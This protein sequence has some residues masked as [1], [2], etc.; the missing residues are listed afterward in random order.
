[1]VYLWLL[2][3]IYDCYDYPDWDSV[4]PPV[5]RRT[6]RPGPVCRPP[7]TRLSRC[8]P[9]P[10]GRGWRNSQ[11]RQTWA[12]T[13]GLGSNQDHRGPGG[14]TVT[15]SLQLS[16]CRSPR[17]VVHHWEG[18]HWRLSQWCSGG[19]WP[20]WVSFSDWN[21]VT[22]RLWDSY[23]LST[24]SPG[25]CLLP[26]VQSEHWEVPTHGELS[27]YRKSPAYSTEKLQYC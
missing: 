23:D 10:P 18:S 5:A 3:I 11:G 16:T 20:W 13:L 19:R 21:W 9:S 4:L 27:K 1:M 7:S 17:M 22:M 8:S 15:T 6:P 26:T 24:P 2:L 25:S 14:T 12:R